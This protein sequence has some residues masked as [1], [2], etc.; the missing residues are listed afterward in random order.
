MK[1]FAGE[2]IDVVESPAVVQL[3]VAQ[4]S[5]KSARR[6]PVGQNERS[7]A[8]TL[9]K[10]PGE[11]VLDVGTGDCACIASIVATSGT[12]VVALDRDRATIIAARKF[13]DTRHLKGIRLLQDDIAASNLPSDSFRNIVCFNVL[14]HVPQL[15]SALAELHRILA[16]DGRLIISDFDEN[17][18]GYLGR[19]QQAV[20]CHFRTVTTHHRWKGR[21]VL[22]CEK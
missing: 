20:D 13:L 17:R 22:S 8:L 5:S 11:P 3:T 7:F 14:H 15:N 16:S 9:M 12:P 21:L 2:A 19:L 10:Y 18:D 1:P 4:T 6:R